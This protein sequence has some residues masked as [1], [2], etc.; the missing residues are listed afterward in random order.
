LASQV[1]LRNLGLIL[2]VFFIREKALA[3]VRKIL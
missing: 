1:Q 3:P 2:L